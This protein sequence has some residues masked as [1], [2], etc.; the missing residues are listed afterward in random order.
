MRHRLQIKVKEQNLNTFEK[1][2]LQNSFI[3]LELLYKIL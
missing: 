3:K 1:K 2:Y